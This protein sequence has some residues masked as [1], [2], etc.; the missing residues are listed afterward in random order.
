MNFETIIRHHHTK[1]THLQTK[2]SD[3]NKQQPQSYTVLLMDSIEERRQA[4]IQRFIRVR[5]QKLKTFFDEAPTMVDF[6]KEHRRSKIFFYTR[7]TASLPFIETNLK[8]GGRFKWI[9]AQLQNQ[10][11]FA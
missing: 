1:L 11:G 9:L 5:E 2:L 3:F 6:L 7:I 8:D 4:M 10:H